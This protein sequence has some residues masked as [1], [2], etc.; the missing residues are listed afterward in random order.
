MQARVSAPRPS[1]QI[2]IIPFIRLAAPKPMPRRDDVLRA[3]V[4]QAN[5]KPCSRSATPGYRCRTPPR[6]MRLIILVAAGIAAVV[7]APALARGLV[8]D[9]I[10]RRSQSVATVETIARPMKI[11]FRPL[12]LRPLHFD[13]F[14][15]WRLRRRWSVVSRRQRCSVSEPTRPVGEILSATSDTL[16]PNVGWVNR[17]TLTVGRPFSR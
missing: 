11:A 3:P 10:R 1:G 15:T 5:G 12:A 6:C 9:L 13:P 16:R 14:D 2:R 7:A 8:L 4:G 17:V